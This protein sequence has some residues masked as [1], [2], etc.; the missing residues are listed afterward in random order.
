MRVQHVWAK[1]GTSPVAF[2]N[3]TVDVPL[4]PA[5]EGCPGVGLPPRSKAN[6]SVISNGPGRLWRRL[7]PLTGW[8]TL[9][10]GRCAAARPSR[11]AP[12]PPGSGRLRRQRPRWPRRHHR[13]PRPAL[14]V[15]PPGGAI[16]PIG[17]TTAFGSARLPRRAGRLR[18]L[19][20]LWCLGH[21]GR[22]WRLG[23]LW[24]PWR[25]FP[26]E[27]SRCGRSGRTVGPQPGRGPGRLE[28]EP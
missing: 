18:R 24:C 1:T 15:A 8:F 9:L 10:S 2:H 5:R 13:W 23:R 16:S 17:A 11:P 3:T 27:P 12:R 25:L 26:L 7:I 28:R 19:G 21:L 20:P 4:C 22:R 6:N 14:S